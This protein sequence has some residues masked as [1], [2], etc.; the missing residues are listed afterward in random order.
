MANIA[1]IGHTTLDLIL[2]LSKD[3]VISSQLEMKNMLCLPYPSK[4]YVEDRFISPGGNAPNVGAG[5]STL[6]HQVF[7][8]SQIGK[9]EIGRMIMESL[10]KFDFDLSQTVIEGKSDMSTILSYKND[11]TILAYHTMHEFACPAS[12]EHVDWIYLSS[13]GFDSF[14][15]FHQRLIECLKTSPTTHI[16]YN[17]GKG[18][19][20][21]GYEALSELLR[22]VHTLI[23]NREELFKLIN[24][25]DDG[26]EVSLKHAIN[27]FG[28]IG[29]RRVVITDGGNGVYYSDMYD[30]L[31]SVSAI[32]VDVV[33]KTGA[34][35]AFSSGYLG[36]LAYGRSELE[37]VMYG[38]IQS[39]RVIIKP[40]ATNGLL[41]LD[42]MNEILSSLDMEPKKIS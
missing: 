10:K 8:V 35:D 3:N 5:L 15:P 14:G 37:S 27:T 39:S 13:L 38:V 25:D 28:T 4:S 36:G 18:E 12:F 32:K 41:T 22:H 40:G 33:E 7:L 21:A 11:R 6:G 24:Q 42:E 26:S 17:P 29:V 34:G 2:F 16:V 30:G 19:I 1:C 20:R 23:V 31:Y 9:G